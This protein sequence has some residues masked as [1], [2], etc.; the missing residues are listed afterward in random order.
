LFAFEKV[1][2]FS[3]LISATPGLILFLQLR[4]FVL[5]MAPSCIHSSKAD[6]SFKFKHA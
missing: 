6:K 4:R 5:H 2:F 3:E 1:R